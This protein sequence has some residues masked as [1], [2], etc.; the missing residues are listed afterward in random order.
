MT[1]ARRPA[2][3]IRNPVNYFSETGGCPFCGERSSTQI[4]QVRYHETAE[5]SGELPDVEG[6]L[7]EC[8]ACGI[9][10]PSHRYEMAAFPKLY[11][12]T[13][14]DYTSFDDGLPQRIRKAILKTILRGQHRPW[15][16]ARL[17]DHLTMHILQPPHVTKA[18]RQLRILDVGCGFGEFLSI[19]RDLGNAVVGTEVLP[20]LVERLRRRGFDCREGELE[21]IDFGGASFDAIIFRAVLYRTRR[22]VE[23]LR[24]ARELLAAGGEIV[25][26][27]PFPGR[28]GADYFLRKQFPQGQ[29][30]ILDADRYFAMLEKRLGLTCVSRQVIYGRAK[31]LLKETRVGTLRSLVSLGAEMVSANLFRYRPYT[32]S[33]VLK[34][35]PIAA[36]AQ[37]V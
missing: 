14:D 4:A 13:Y 35:M 22:P 33:Y 7:Y 27:D 17:L 9:A 5:A 21:S 28:D 3:A 11:R 8:A 32:L 37:L 23:T 2:D 25:C 12:K 19:Y 29:F 1:P 31:T 34:P 24:V 16:A 36:A 30:Y 18:A 10:Y 20:Q 15:S 6:R 26:V